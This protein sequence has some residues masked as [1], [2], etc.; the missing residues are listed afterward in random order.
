MS[1]ATN[2]LKHI[3][4]VTL[5]GEQLKK[6]LEFVNPDGDKDLEQLECEVC[7]AHL[8]AHEVQGDDMVEQMPAGLYAWIAE[9]SEEG[10][11]PLFDVK[12]A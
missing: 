8:P 11:I 12:G 5:T 9:Y 4:Q 3:R 7:I 1:D 10:C 6:A 2:V